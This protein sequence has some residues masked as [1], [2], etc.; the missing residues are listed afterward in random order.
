MNQDEVRY[1]YPPPDYTLQIS[2][3]GSVVFLK[4]TWDI[5]TMSECSVLLKRLLNTV[6]RQKLRNCTY[7]L[8]EIVRIDSAGMLVLLQHVNAVGDSFSL[9]LDVPLHI[10]KLYEKIKNVYAEPVQP[11]SIP[12]FL[13]Y[14]ANIGKWLEDTVSFYKKLLAFFG[15]VVVHLFRNLLS[16]QSFQWVSTVY[17]M[18]HIGVRAIPI[19][20]LLSFLVGTVLAYMSATAFSRF[21]AQVYIV[22]LLDI[23]ILRELGVLLTAILISGR[24]SASCT[25]S[26]GSMINN[27]EIASMRVI[28][29]DPIDYLVLPRLVALLCMFPLLTMVANVTAIIGGMLATWMSVNISP[30]AFWSLFAE[31][32]SLTSFFL[33]IG[34]AP[35][36]AIIITTVG[37]FY[38]FQASGKADEVGYLTTESVVQSLFLCIVFDAF[39]ALLYSRLGL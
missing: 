21:G 14:L 38:G 3:E 7:Y 5:G 20:A 4:G 18:E 37:C 34:K 39:F 30:P 29:V 17:H 26:I 22:N 12:F 8:N 1:F 24:T 33:G 10:Q 11:P 27:E 35:V 25:A 28:G 6:R 16:I 23:A 36:F 31:A 9:T 15:S 32:T 13:L 19:I 2:D